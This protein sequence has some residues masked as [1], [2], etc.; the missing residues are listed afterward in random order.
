MTFNNNPTAEDLEKIFKGFDEDQTL[1]K[2]RNDFVNDLV[3]FGRASN[4]GM[5]D[6]VRQLFNQTTS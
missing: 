2:L 3:T 4:K 5:L 6:R 1:V